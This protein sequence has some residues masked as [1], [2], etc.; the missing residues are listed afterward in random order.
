MLGSIPGNSTISEDLTGA[1]GEAQVGKFFIPLYDEPT[2]IIHRFGGTYVDAVRPE[3][4]DGDRLW[5]KL[6]QYVPTAYCAGNSREGGV[7]AWGNIKWFRMTIFNTGIDTTSG[8]RITM[9]LGDHL[10]LSCN[11]AANAPTIKT[12]TF[13][14]GSGGK[15]LTGTPVNPVLTS[16]PVIPRDQWAALQFEILFK[17]DETGDVRVWMDDTLIEELSGLQTLPDKASDQYLKYMVQGE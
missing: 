10:D 1:Y 16:P 15:G 3:I 14:G 4:L 9:Q 13:E 7:P 6:K 12:F 17:E 2:E 11:S 5:V 8:S